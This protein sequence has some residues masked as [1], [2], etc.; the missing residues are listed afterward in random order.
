MRR[1][2][3][4]LMMRGKLLG[5]AITVV[6]REGRSWHQR[7]MTDLGESGADAINATG[8]IAGS[9]F[10]TSNT[11]HATLWTGNTKTDLGTLGGGA[12][13]GQGI[14]DS[15]QVVGFSQIANSFLEH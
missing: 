8:Q 11:V 15:G 7:T 1:L 5:G 12:A 6:G 13:F 14:N 9:T 4:T 3:K 10:V 2:L